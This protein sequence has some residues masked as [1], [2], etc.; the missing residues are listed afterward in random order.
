[1]NY[2][3]NFVPFFQGTKYCESILL[4]T[5]RT[6]RNSLRAAFFN[7]RTETHLDDKDRLDECCRFLH[8]CDAY[9]NVEQNDSID[10]S[11]LH[12]E[13]VHSFRGCLKE[14][15]TS[16]SN[17]LAF[18]HSINAT[19]CYAKEHPIIK[20]FK[21][22]AHLGP[23]SQHERTLADIFTGRCTQYEFDESQPKKFQIFDLP[24]IVPGVSTIADSLKISY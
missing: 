10:K 6:L 15:N 1:M 21:F 24:F 13:C 5:V 19:K 9:K 20:C 4:P 17:D 7:A 2:F 11:I 12:C 16:L 3:E 23:A 14:L 18:I 22:E 8:K